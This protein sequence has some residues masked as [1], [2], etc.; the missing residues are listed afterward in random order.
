M[1]SWHTQ[2][3]SFCGA[4]CDYLEAAAE[5]ERE[6]AEEASHEQDPEWITL[7]MA[8]SLLLKAAE[9]LRAVV[10]LD[11]QNLTGPTYAVARSLFEVLVDM[12]FLIHGD[13]S[14]RQERSRLVWCC[15]ILEDNCVRLLAGKAQALAS[16]DDDIPDY[17]TL[18]KEALVESLESMSGQIEFLAISAEDSE[19]LGQL[20]GSWK[21]LVRDKGCR[22]L[23]TI[24]RAARP[25][26]AKRIQG[27][28]EQHP[29][30]RIIKNLEFSYRV[31]YGQA[32]AFVHSSGG[33]YLAGRGRPIEHLR[34]EPASFV[35]LVSRDIVQFSSAVYHVD[36]PELQR[37]VLRQADLAL[38][39]LTATPPMT[40]ET[41]DAG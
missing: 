12:L 34:A 32:S 36:L 24:G 37:T 26:M 39:A 41:E 11:S 38:G 28:K 7:S 30:P 3:A 29:V 5:I 40:P 27:I 31:I 22:A 20:V 13:P 33:V 17:D 6:R 10:C 21:D 19:K 8:R 18:Q 23:A 16:N 15:S 4:S 1:S 2:L 25:S 9:D 14:V 35:V